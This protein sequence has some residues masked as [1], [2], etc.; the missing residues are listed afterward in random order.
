MGLSS[1]RE[2]MNTTKL[3]LLVF[4]VGLLSLTFLVFNASRVS[5]A[6][7]APASGT[8]TSAIGIQTVTYNWATSTAESGNHWWVLASSTNR[9]PTIA[10]MVTTSPTSTIV[11]FT[12][13]TLA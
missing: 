10:Q 5:A 13:V 12:F 4:L 11:S 9:V 3:L 7:A 2:K 6:T 8:S 1:L